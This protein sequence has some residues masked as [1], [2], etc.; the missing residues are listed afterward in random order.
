MP[1]NG[2]IA[3]AGRISAPGSAGRGAIHTPP[4]SEERERESLV[5]YLFLNNVM[6]GKSFDQCCQTEDQALD[7]QTRTDAVISFYLSA[8]MCPP[9]GIVHPRPHYGTIPTPRD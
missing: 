4:V 2:L 1:K 7:I 9:E 8:T 3:M 5:N 6:H